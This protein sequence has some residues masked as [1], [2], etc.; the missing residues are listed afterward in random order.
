M[1]EQDA[2]D[3]IAKEIIVKISVNMFYMN[4][5][6]N[7]VN[8]LMPLSQLQRQQPKQTGVFPHLDERVQGFPR[9]QGGGLQ[10]PVDGERLIQRHLQQISFQLQLLQLGPGLRRQFHHLAR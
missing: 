1:Y 9:W 10:D 6:L 2:W 7:V 5:Y 4:S 8:A 3:D